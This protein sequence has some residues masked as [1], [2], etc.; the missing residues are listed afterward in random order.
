MLSSVCVTTL[1]R[2]LKLSN[3]VCTVSRLSF[4]KN[5]LEIE[6]RMATNN[7][8]M[9]VSLESVHACECPSTVYLI[10]HHV[11]VVRWLTE[12]CPSNTAVELITDG[13]SLTFRDA[14]DQLP[15][16]TVCV[17]DTDY[18]VTYMDS[19][20]TV[21]R[22]IQFSSVQLAHILL[23]LSIVSAIVD[24]AIDIDNNMTFASHD[25]VVG[26]IRFDKKLSS[27][28]NSGTT[29]VATTVVINFSKHLV[30]TL[31]L[32]KTCNFYFKNN[33]TVVIEA[34]STGISMSF[35]PP[36]NQ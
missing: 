10:N 11:T 33:S 8:S 21:V 20:A 36:I 18:G 23:N 19:H 1:A 25:D 29:P 32:S 5:S 34:P 9:F 17:S 30:S 12:V 15:P 16:L 6:T 2:I 27:C 22:S 7:T 4:K 13:K 14:N 28:T 31:L 26:D 35:G 24:I 3:D